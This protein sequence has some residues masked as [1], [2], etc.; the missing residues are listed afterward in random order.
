[1]QLQQYKYFTKH[2]PFV[3]YLDHMNV[4]DFEEIAEWFLEEKPICM[5]FDV[6]RMMVNAHAKKNLF[7]RYKGTLEK[8]KLSHEAFCSLMHRFGTLRGFIIWPFLPIH[9]D[10]TW[11]EID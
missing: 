8:H 10:T 5:T 4:I 11:F 2:D 3:Y 6:Y 9:D 1:M 7:V